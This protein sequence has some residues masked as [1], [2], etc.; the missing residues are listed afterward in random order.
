GFGFSSITHKCEDINECL[1]GLHNCAHTEVCINLKG[2]YK[3]T[4]KLKSCEEGFQFSSLTGRCEDKNECLE[5]PRRCSHD[6]INTLGSY[7]CVC[8][9]GYELDLSRS[10]CVDFDECEYFRQLK[11]NNSNYSIH[12]R[13]CQAICTNTP[14]SYK[15]DCP[16]GFTLNG[17]MCDDIN[18][19]ENKA[20]CGSIDSTCLNVPGDY[21]CFHLKCPQ[22]YVKDE[23]QKNRCV[24]KK[25]ISKRKCYMPP[26]KPLS[27][28][29]DYVAV[30]SNMNN[31]QNR[32]H[33]FVFYH[34]AK[35]FERNSF[36]IEIKK[37]S[38][39]SHVAKAT[40]DHFRLEKS[41][42]WVK[43]YYSKPLE[44]P[45]EVT[46]E[47]KADQ[48]LN[49]QLISRHIAIIELIVYKRYEF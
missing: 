5:L 22:E 13:P 27:I 1:E 21:K 38:G 31:L 29:Y 47:L 48:Y 15:C 28:S 43:I 26:T 14:G 24:L 2:T 44:A 17:H 23:F 8:P 16:T 33:F 6:C 49:Q 9:S 41:S 4:G 39:Q 30:A 42:H 37:S 46:L 11:R 18:E 32:P 36:E 40:V 45:Q 10:N 35:N 25:E 34:H 20:K 7:R 12:G 19:C 3:C